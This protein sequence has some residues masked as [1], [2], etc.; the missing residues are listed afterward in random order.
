MYN[1]FFDYILSE[2]GKYISFFVYNF[3]FTRIGIEETPRS[4]ISNF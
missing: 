1:I 3:L 2:G 4:F